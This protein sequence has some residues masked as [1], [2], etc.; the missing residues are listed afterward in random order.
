MRVSVVIPCYNEEESLPEL[1]REAAG[2]FDSARLDAEVIVV[3]DGSTDDSFARAAAAAEQDARIKVIRLRR[4]FGQTA[5]M[6]AGIDRASGDVI[7]PMDADR[8]NDP[9]DIPRLLEAVA[10]GSDVASGWRKSRKDAALTRRVPSWLANRLI[11]AI[12]GVRLHDYGCTL[13]A[14]R[15]EVMDEVRLYGEMHRFIP[16]HA[17]WA[18]ARVTEL[19][20]N[21]RPRTAGR[22]KYGLSRTFKV[23]L[24]LITVTFL[25][26]YATKPLY[27]FGFLGMLLMGCGLFAGGETLVEKFVYGTKVHTNPVILL[28]V[29]LSLAGL[30]LVLIGLLAEILTRTYHEATGRPIYVVRETRNLPRS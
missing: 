3:D 25:G 11:S 19:E 26:R 27:F 17:V 5:A 21:H 9:A 29:F 7:V 22:S 18:G 6:V 14:Y 15:R 12:T 16:I 1:L 13:K 8:Q 4:N 23:I 28:A 24:D 10:A 2:V 30:Q 20:V